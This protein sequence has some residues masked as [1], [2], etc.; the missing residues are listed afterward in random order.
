MSMRGSP[1]GSGFSTLRRKCLIALFPN[2]CLIPKLCLGMPL[3]EKLCFAS[4][5]NRVCGPTTN[6]YWPV[7]AHAEAQ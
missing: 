4:K 5:A 6:L 2:F 1:A 3:A 7:Q